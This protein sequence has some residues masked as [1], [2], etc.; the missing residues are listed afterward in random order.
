MLPPITLA[1]QD[2][3]DALP[4]P[5]ALFSAT[6]D[7]VPQVLAANGGFLALAR[8]G[9]GKADI[10]AQMAAAHLLAQPEIAGSLDRCSVSEE[11]VYQFEWLDG[12]EIASR[13]YTVSLTRLHGWGQVRGSILMTL[14]DRT[15]AVEAERSL[16]AEMLRDS[17]TGLPNRAAFI[18][19][20]DRAI[21]EDGELGAFAILTVDLTRF[22]RVNESMGSLAGDELI[23][24]VARRL[25][26]ALRGGDLL[27][28]LAGDEFGVLLKLAD[29][30]GDALHAA[31][32][33]HAVL[34]AP[35]RLTDLEIR[36]D[37][38]IGC[39]LTTET[40]AIAEDLVRN[41][42]FA[43]K[44]AKRSGKV[45]VY[46]PGEAADARRRFSMETE[47]RR[48]IDAGELTLV[49]QPLV[50]LQ[51]DR[52]AGFE[53]LARWEHPTEGCI[54]PN[55][56]VPVAEESGLI[57]PLGRWALAEATQTLA[58]WDRRAGAP[59]PIYLGV[60]LSPVQLV[61]DD[62]AKIAQQALEDSGLSGKRLMLELT[63]SAII[64]DPERSARLLNQLKA[65]EAT[66]AM[67]DFGTGYSSLAYLQKLPID[68]LK[69]DRSFVTGMLQD[70][71]SIAI[72]RA[73]LGLASALGMHT[74][75]E[76]IETAELANTLAAL[77]CTCG[78]GY[79]FSRPLEAQAA[80]D[81]CQAF[82][83][84]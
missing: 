58:D 75:A 56:F 32:R 38:A 19:A 13:H 7:A 25:M 35:F 3:L 76:G 10:T 67:D 37:C 24:T 18:E 8:N 28:R 78:Q 84:R 40:V 27:A 63:E 39:S 73:I 82:N 70:R 65:L 46:Q 61:R 17:L 59:L 23:I 53:A 55:D 47:L 77:G 54:S 45:E 30:P 4:I 9:R 79:Y 6:G 14:I 33:I 57:V 48:A 83:Q 43:L 62:V 68:V 80:F 21:E 51:H 20:V 31:R 50:D 36:I 49:Y 2:Y 34:A 81:Y 41:A 52:I 16:R 44:R 60:N 11:P 72:V 42:Q 64:A 26:S 71:D 12:S 74:T 1:P 22:S 66:V 5:A 29:G 15:A 69:I